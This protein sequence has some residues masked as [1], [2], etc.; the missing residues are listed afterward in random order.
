MFIQIQKS[1][2]CQAFY[3][4]WSLFLFREILLL[5]KKDT[6]KKIELISFYEDSSIELCLTRFLP[7]KETKNRL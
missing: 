4:I 1:F 6:E 3:Y 2:N 7:V 5:K